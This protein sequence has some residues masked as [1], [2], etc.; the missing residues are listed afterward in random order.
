MQHKIWC[1][2]LKACQIE[3]DDQQLKLVPFLAHSSVHE[4]LFSCAAPSIVFSMGSIRVVSCSILLFQIRILAGWIGIRLNSSNKLILTRDI[5]IHRAVL[6]L[7]LYIIWKLIWNHTIYK[8]AWTWL[9]AFVVLIYIL[10]SLNTFF[11]W[12]LILKYL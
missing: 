12:G 3:R 7:Y 9:F 4:L 8:H 2:D 5:F 11:F 10:F 1:L 6:G